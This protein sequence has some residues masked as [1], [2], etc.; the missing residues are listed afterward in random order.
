MTSGQSGADFIS[1]LFSLSGKTAIVTGGTSGIGHMIA[2][3]FVQAGAKTY[4]TSR[5]ADA[6]EKTAMEL[7]K[8]GECIA[9][10]GDVGTQEG[11]IAIADA[12]RRSE[13]K[14]ESKLDIL[15]NAAGVTWGAPMKEYPDKAWDKVLGVNIKGV[16]HLTTALVEELKAAGNEDDPAKI[17]NIGSV[18]G[19][20]APPW[21]SYAYSASKGGV[22]QLTRHL[23]K[24]LGP[25]HIVVNAIA[26]GPFPSRMMSALIEHEGEELVKETATGR[27]GRA[28]DMAGV[29]IYLAS[30]AGANVTGTIIPVDG[31]YGTL[32]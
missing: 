5:K 25:Q 15:V 18:H 30:R 7:S 16:F 24:H 31:G 17:I 28:D 9:L 11:C 1:R 22:H 26:P 21:E 14:L 2:S 32:R 20:V 27:L 6:C 13:S 19:F 23:A 12:Y 8:L 4:V 3:A 10:P 29:A